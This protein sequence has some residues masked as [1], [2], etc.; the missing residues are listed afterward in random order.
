MKSLLFILAVTA[1]TTSSYGRGIP[2]KLIAPSR[3]EVIKIYP[4]DVLPEGK[5]K[6]TGYV[7]KDNSN[8]NPIANVLVST[9]DRKAFTHTD[10]SGYYELLLDADDTSLF[11]FKSE[12]SEHVIWKYEFKERYVFEINFYLVDDYS[13]M[14]MDKPVIYLYS[15]KDETVA[16]KFQ[17]KG[18]I[19]FTYPLYNQDQGWEVNVS[20]NV[21]QSKG[22]EYPYLF[23]EAETADLQ[24]H[25]MNS[26]P[27]GSYIKTDTAVQFL[28]NSLTRLGLNRTE[29]TDFITFWLPKLLQKDYAFIQFVIDDDYEAHIS[30]M[31]VNPAPENMRRVY[32]IFTL[33]DQD[34]LGRSYESQHF[35][36]FNRE[37]FT[38]VE[39]GGTQKPN[40]EFLTHDHVE[41]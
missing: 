40:C 10:S 15:E 39:W 26:R 5:C 16:I 36:S 28:E 27:Y 33:F 1:L 37:G 8:G 19:I 7:L 14:I 25:K 41:K 18:E 24:Y 38:L 29:Q 30:A 31:A 34:E 32:M 17:P 12:L 4:Q 6:V 3:H 22:K 35:P 20:G 11:A 21:I 9:P 13:M 23:W 2:E